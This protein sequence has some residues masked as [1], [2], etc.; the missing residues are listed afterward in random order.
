MSIAA[1][2]IMTSGV[3]DDKR[4]ARATIATRAIAEAMAHLPRV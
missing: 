2:D 1:Q 3:L 4:L